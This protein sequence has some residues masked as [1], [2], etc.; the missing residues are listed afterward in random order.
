MAIKIAVANQKGGTGKTTTSINLGACLVAEE[1][2]VLLVDLDPQGNLSEGLNVVLGDGETG[3]YEFLMGRVAPA[4]VVRNTE[5][6]G[7]FIIP[8]HIEL[9]AA[10]AELIGEIGREQQLRAALSEIESEYD[11]VIIDTPPTLGVLS[12]NALAAADEVLISMQPQ[13]F[14]LAG[15]STLLDIVK[16]VQKKV[17]PSLRRWMVLATMI[18]FRRGEDK[19]MLI[20]VRERYGERVFQTEIRVNSK[21]IEASRNGVPVIIYDRSSCGAREYSM[22]ARELVGMHE[23]AIS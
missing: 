12:I 7:L 13:A 6:P 3:A 2:K 22:L 8:S 1:K 11:Y 9:A 4:S 14:A 19:K 18:D 23:V 17:N 10:E 20:K 21:L 5:L 15:V 16:T